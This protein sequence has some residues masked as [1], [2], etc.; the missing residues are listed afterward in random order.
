M[1]GPWFSIRRVA[2]STSTGS[3][4]AAGA[5]PATTKASASALVRTGLASGVIELPP[6]L[7]HRHGDRVRQV[8]AAVA[9]T[10]G[11]PEAIL[12]G[13][14]LEDRRRQPGGL[15]AEH[16]H[17]VAR[18]AHVGEEPLAARREG[19]HAPPAHGP[20]ERRP[21]VVHRDARILVVVEAGA[22]Q[23]LVVERKAERPHEMQARAGVRGEPDHV[24]GAPQDLALD[25]R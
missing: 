24:P 20:C 1:A 17:V 18:I 5:H 21:G 23:L 19:E 10:H 22:L 14:F 11:E 15:P 3:R 8:E 12:R 2:V 7:E 13:E 6:G 9:G 4:Y 16:E 25:E